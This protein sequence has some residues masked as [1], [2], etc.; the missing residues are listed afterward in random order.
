MTMEALKTSKVEWAKLSCLSCFSL[1]KKVLTAGA[2]L[3]A[4]F[5]KNRECEIKSLG[6][7]VNSCFVPVYNPL[8]ASLSKQ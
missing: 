6:D 2:S 3:I 8:A 5:I 4:R 7:A 1:L